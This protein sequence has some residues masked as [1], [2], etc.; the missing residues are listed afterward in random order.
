VRNF[1]AHI[2]QAFQTDEVYGVHFGENWVSVDRNVDYDKTYAAIGEVVDGYPGLYRDLQT[3]LKERIREVLT[4]AGEA[5]I[6][7]IYGPDL[8]VL[9]DKA[10]EVRQA[11]EGVEGLVRL[12]KELMA[13]IPHVQVQMDMDKARD[14]GLKPGDLRRASARLMAGEEMGDIY[15]EGR[16]YDVQVWTP[17][18]LRHNV[19]AYRQMLF[20]TP[21]GQRV[22][23]GEV[24]DVRILPTPDSIKREGG[25]RRIDVQANLGDRDLASVAAD[26]EARLARVEWPLGYHAVLTGEIVEL[27]AAR[28]RLLLLS[29]LSAVGIYFLLQ[30]S[31]RSWRLAT[32]SFLSLPSA[33]VGGVLATYAAVGVISLGSLVGFLTVL[34]IAARNGILMIDHFQHLERHEGE[35]FGM[36]LVLRGAN[37]R[38]RPIV[39]TAG[40]TALAL[41]PLVV[42][43]N[44]PGHEIEHP[45]A[46]VILGGLV[47]S[48]LLNLFVV[49]ALYLRF[50]AGVVRREDSADASRLS[51]S[52]G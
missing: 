49:P 10:E 51:A 3:Y 18:R 46:V 21:S 17:P 43:G 1:G 26:V 47:T 5:I 19:E 33:L 24:A 22:R 42:Y 29:I 23:L 11:L 8:Q 14:Y 36:G 30:V 41:V 31:L 9:R 28:T 27:R 25:S 52:P 34:G 2:G 37:E 7:R 20:D 13:E 39:M 50:G 38:L 16:T 32:L 6:V 12:K 4:G 48:T 45:M 40:T 15:V 35:P 44:L